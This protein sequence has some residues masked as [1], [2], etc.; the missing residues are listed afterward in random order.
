[1][2][3]RERP[4]ITSKTNELFELHGKIATIPLVFINHFVRQQNFYDHYM[5]GLHPKPIGF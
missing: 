2:K 3:E 1:M 5:S 4:E